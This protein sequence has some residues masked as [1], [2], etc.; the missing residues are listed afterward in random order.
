[1]NIIYVNLLPLPPAP[2]R[3]DRPAVEGYSVEFVALT[4]QNLGIELVE[5]LRDSFLHLLL[6][7]PL[8]AELD[9]CPCEEPNLWVR[10]LFS[11]R[12]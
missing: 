12:S 7:N 9:T 10:S 4:K 8:F 5:R 11:S 1:M 3:T 6:V 2:K